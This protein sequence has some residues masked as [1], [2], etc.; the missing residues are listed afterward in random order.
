MP[1]QSRRFLRTLT[2]L[3]ASLSLC[4][5]FALAQEAKPGIQPAE[6]KLDRPVDFDKDIVPIFDEK[7]TA[8]HNV[9]ISESRFNIEDIPAILKGGKRGPGVVPK[10]PDK[11][12]IYTAA[13]RSMTQEMHMPPLPNNVSA[14]AVTPEELGL[15]RQWILE[16][17]TSS[18][19][20][21]SA[22]IAWQS[23]PENLNSI[24]GLALSPW[25]R[26]VACG[27]ANQLDVYDLVVGDYVGR[28]TDPALA[29]VEVNGQK[30]YPRGAAH[31]DFV[32]SVAFNPAGDLMAT[33][34]FRVVKL[35]QRP[36][37]VRSL[38]AAVEQAPTAVA[39]SPDGK[40]YA[41]GFADG[42]VRLLQASDGAVAKAL[43][44]HAGAVRSLAFDAASTLVFSAGADKSVRQW[45]IADGAQSGLLD[46]PAE[47]LSIALA[48][49]GKR[50]FT[51]HADNLI[52]GWNVPF[53][54]PKPAEGD[55]AAQP[56]QPVLTSQGHGGPVNALA[57]VAP[58]GAQLVSGS[59]DGTVRLWD[60]ANGNQ[61][62]AYGLDAPVSAVA[63][64]PDGQALA[65]VG[66]PRARLWQLADGKQLAEVKG[67]FDADRGIVQ[68]T[69]NETVAK[70]R[71]ALAKAAQEQAEKTVKEREESLKKAMETKTNADK[72]LAEAMPKEQTAKEAVDAAAKE[73]AD[74]PDDEALKKKKTDA[75]AAL[76]KET[77]AV[78]KAKEAVESANRAITQLEQ[79]LKASQELQQAETARHAA[80]NTAAEQATAKLNEAK[81]ALPSFEK[82]LA[83][84][85]F[86]PNGRLFAVGG[87]DGVVRT[88]DAKAGKPLD[89]L[90]QGVAVQ[91]LLFAPTGGL[92]SITAE[93]KLT[94]WDDDPAWRLVGVLGPNPET[95]LDVGNSP[96]ISRVLA[97]AFSPDGKL[98]ATGGGDPSRSGELILWDVASRSIARVI[99]E[100]HSDT[101]FSVEFSREGNWL[102][103]GAADKFVKLFNVADGK[104][105][106]AFEG[107]THHV[108]GVTLKS[109]NSRIASA[110]AD[111]AIK[112][113]NV[114]TGEQHRTISNYGKQ[115]TAIEYIGVSDNI[116]SGSG[117]KN[118]RMHRSNDGG[119]YRNFA[120]MAEFVYAVD[121]AR[122][123]SLIVAGGEDGV[124]RVWN[125]TN[126]QEL[127]KFDPPKPPS[128][129]QAAR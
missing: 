114:E 35:W 88:Y 79:G 121:V 8:C 17:A 76:A 98:L 91:K 126:A 22:S 36:S 54:Q 67:S 46:T 58:A 53:D 32:Q 60:L 23:I 85:T 45:T 1:C 123:E 29:S 27:R 15:I 107:H 106:R 127:F 9:A 97:L 74:K 118:V 125:G 117:D 48:A 49:D 96:F 47:I 84:I 28:L 81:A 86:S 115:V 26:F 77:E 5:A 25:N 55:Q 119:N 66:G 51:G 65:G 21:S 78:T 30:L 18:E 103:S 33:G 62:R 129:Q 31:R 14:A 83:A 102:V 3:L 72:A 44:G 108:L 94:V 40:W 73:L 42:G 12:L 6:V 43:N 105:I 52:R 50:V 7:C 116:A 10:D 38:D 82:P 4:P 89:T 111:N 34:G 63:V 101:V 100:A 19:S 59:Q 39:A 13:A 112:I 90:Q 75:D 95:P 69:E 104:L 87:E 109:D 11:S 80:E 24:Y 70:S 61:V 57:L 110:G 128:D 120:G 113:W 2:L 93:P 37:N 68:L 20:K 99:E 92:V 124:L 56:V 41:V 64:R 122:D 71:A 16:G